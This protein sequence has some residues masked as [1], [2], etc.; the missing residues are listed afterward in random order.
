[1]DELHRS[2]I[3]LRDAMTRASLA[4]SDLAFALEA[5]EC[6]HGD[7]VVFDADAV[8]RERAAR[9][10]ADQLNRLGR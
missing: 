10:A 6:V 9:L 1:M 3:E 5:H 4:L 8:G 2:L 7:D